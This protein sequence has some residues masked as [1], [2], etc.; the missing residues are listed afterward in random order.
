ML[1]LIVYFSIMLLNYILC[2]REMFEDLA[3]LSFSTQQS[4]LNVSDIND[5]MTTKINERS[6]QLAN[7]INEIEKVGN[8]RWEILKPS[9]TTTNIYD[10]LLYINRLY[11]VINQIKEH[12]AKYSSLDPSVC[13]NFDKYCK[14]EIEQ[15]NL[16]EMNNKI[17]DMSES[18]VDPK[19]DSHDPEH[20]YSTLR[21]SKKNEQRQ[22]YRANMQKAQDNKLN[23][24]LNLMY[25]ANLLDNTASFK[26]DHASLYTESAIEFS[27]RLDQCIVPH[28]HAMLKE[29]DIIQELYYSFESIFDIL[30]RN[31]VIV[32][33]NLDILPKDPLNPVYDINFHAIH[34]ELKTTSS[35]PN[36][37]YIDFVNELRFF[38]DIC[39]LKTEKL[40]ILDEHLRIKKKGILK[41]Y[42]NLHIL[43]NNKK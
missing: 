4:H 1:F 8:N 41:N 23:T 19:H 10:F 12:N 24:A 15:Q 9:T 34:G 26:S 18:S 21:E 5:S 29:A 16:H 3:D 43:F 13:N 31:R 38:L 22:E 28:C 37:Q 33:R 32:I 14:F 6:Q 40:K 30:F 36:P 20:Y 2:S 17:Q 35:S 11:K 7:F 27:K 42:E 39:K 25:E